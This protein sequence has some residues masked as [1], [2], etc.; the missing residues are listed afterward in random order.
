MSRKAAVILSRLDS[1]RFPGKALAPLAGKTLLERCIDALH[2]AAGFAVIL[3]TTD[4]PLDDPLAAVAERAGI[5]CFRGA[6]DDVARRVGDCLERHGIDLFARV[7]GD[8]PFPNKGLISAGFSILEGG[9]YDFVTNLVPRA[10]PYGISLEA[11]R[12]DVFIS[13]CPGFNPHQREH[14]TAWFY[15]N[16]DKCRAYFYTYTHGNDHDV[17]LVVDTPEDREI[18]E[19]LLAG[20]SRNETP[21]VE[22]IVRTY[23]RLGLHRG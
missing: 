20:L 19:K 6:C 7:N 14:I 18:L 8:S 11:L 9:G 21:S 17:R 2:P 23:R 10:F 1:R 16:M 22:E 15:E 3:A 4:R 13:R 5:A 12:S